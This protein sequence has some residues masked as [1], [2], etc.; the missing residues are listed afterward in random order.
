MR[1]ALADAGLE[2]RDVDYLNAHGTGTIPNDHTEKLA[3]D[4][5]FAEGGVT[6][7]S[8]KRLHG[9]TLGG[10]GAL[11]AA[12]SLALMHEMRLEHVLSN[13]FGFGGNDASLV[14]AAPP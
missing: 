7:E 14:F 9:H 1:R 5:I 4:R 12:V 8:T 10:A 11:E 6:F 3:I 13:S 2:P